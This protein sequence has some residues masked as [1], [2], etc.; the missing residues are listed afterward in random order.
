MG[1]KR[2]YRQAWELSLE[3]AAMQVQGSA[4]TLLA[5]AKRRSDKGF[6]EDQWSCEREFVDDAGTYVYHSHIAIGGQSAERLPWLAETFFNAAS[7]STQPWYPEFLGG[8]C[9]PLSLPPE[10]GVIAQ[11]LA[12]GCFDVGLRQP[13]CYRQL[14]SLI[15]PDAS[16]AVVVAR[17]V[18]EGPVLPA[19]SRLAY[20][21]DPNGEVLLWRNACLHWHHICCTPGAALFSGR[22]DRW[23]I[24]TLRALGLD[25]PER[26]TYRREAELLRDWLQSKACC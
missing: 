16:S 26:N 17:S 5:M 21:L 23:L 10:E 7:L 22:A 18:K 6:V 14:V 8:E 3:R 11:Q 25:G 13:R 4:E 24:N 20:T 1:L 19:R 9:Q 12:L 2:G 15:K